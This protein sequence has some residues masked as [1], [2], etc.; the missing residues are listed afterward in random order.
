MQAIIGCGFNIIITAIH[1]IHSLGL[2][3]QSN[4]SGPAEF[5]P[6]DPISI[7]PIHKGP[8][9]TWFPIQSIPVGEEEVPKLKHNN[10][11]VTQDILFK[12]NLT[13]TIKRGSKL[14]LNCPIIMT[15]MIYQSHVALKDLNFKGIYSNILLA[16]SSDSIGLRIKP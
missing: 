8:L 16:L 7:G 6:D 11:I 9:Q 3:V 10:L 1:P 14:K 13:S 4:P 5:G 2:K 15:N 12:S